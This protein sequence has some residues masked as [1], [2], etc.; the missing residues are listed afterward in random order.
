MKGWAFAFAL[1]ALLVAGIAGGWGLLI[2]FALALWN[3]PV[4]TLLV[5]LVLLF[6]LCCCGR[7]KRR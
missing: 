4:K 6:V 1:F 7:H 2:L 3:W 5:F